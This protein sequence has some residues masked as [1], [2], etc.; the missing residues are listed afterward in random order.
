M[1]YINEQLAVLTSR[2]PELEWKIS[3]LSSL[4]SRKSLPRGLFRSNGE[5]TGTVCVEEIKAD[6]HAL[7]RQDNGLSAHY[8]ADRIKQKVNVLVALCQRDSRIK[9]PEEQ[10]D[11]GIKMLSTRQQWIQ[12]LEQ[13]ISTLL[14]QQQAMTK[15]L[16][17]MKLNANT[18]A[19]LGLQGELGEVERRLTLARE[20]LNKAVS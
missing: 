9:K 4:I 3:G 11:F 19:I 7:S 10:V 15:A 13:D 17:Q 18:T 6:I 2:L 8:L 16:E 12:T 1:K 5:L 14:M 20:A